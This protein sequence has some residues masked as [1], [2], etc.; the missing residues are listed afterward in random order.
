MYFGET[1]HQISYFW[2]ESNLSCVVYLF[3]CHLRTDLRLSSSIITK[4]PW[5]RDFGS[6][7][8]RREFEKKRL[9]F[10][11]FRTVRIW[12]RV[13][14]TLYVREIK[15]SLLLRGWWFFLPLWPKWYIT[16]Q[17]SNRKLVGELQMWSMIHRERAQGSAGMNTGLMGAR[18]NW[19]MPGSRTE[20]MYR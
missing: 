9:I 1:K 7:S 3:I 19:S 5:Y 18:R 15:L 13:R 6:K 20:A 8:K 16:W 12:C 17:D 2:C 14:S 11:I 10:G 4:K